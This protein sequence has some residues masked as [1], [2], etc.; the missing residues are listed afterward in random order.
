M[1]LL[2]KYK[3]KGLTGLANLGNT[4]FINSTLQC[5]SHT[6]ELNEYLDNKLNKEF[7]NTTIDLLFLKE[8]DELRKLIW[9]SNCIIS[10]KKFLIN[11]HKIARHKDKEIFTGFAQNDLPEFLLFMIDA[12]HNALKREVHIEI[13]GKCLNNTDTLAVKCYEMMKNMYSKEY[14]EILQLF[15]GIHVSVIRDIEDKNK[16][17]SQTP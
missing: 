3:D 6:Y 11:L 12:F 17:Y 9:S 13:K 4:C 7:S 2:D 16:I 8:W 10:P 5:I 1:D 14:S 15:Y